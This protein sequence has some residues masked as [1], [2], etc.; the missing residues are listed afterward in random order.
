MSGDQWLKRLV[1]VLGLLLM[2]PLGYGL[3]TG[4]LSPEDAG[5]RAAALFIGVVVARKMTALAPS[6]REVLVPVQTEILE[7]HDQ[8]A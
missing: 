1:A 8:A 7:E 4:S 5:L 2:L 3:V 6:G